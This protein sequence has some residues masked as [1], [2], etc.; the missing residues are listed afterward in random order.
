MEEHLNDI[1]ECGAERM[2]R[3]ARWEMDK[4]RRESELESMSLNTTTEVLVRKLNGG[5]AQRRSMQP[6][7]LRVM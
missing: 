4:V 3:R 7:R 1:A 2:R 5:S 6:S